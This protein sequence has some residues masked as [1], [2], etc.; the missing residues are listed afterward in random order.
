MCVAAV[1]VAPFSV[2][3]EQKRKREG[4]EGGGGG[5]KGRGLGNDVTEEKKR[6]PC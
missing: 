6:R 1:V 3:K 4:R 2:V 5:G